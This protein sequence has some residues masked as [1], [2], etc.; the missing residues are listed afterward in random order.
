MADPENHCV[1]SICPNHP[2]RSVV[3]ELPFAHSILYL[4]MAVGLAICLPRVPSF[5]FNPTAPITTPTNTSKPVVTRGPTANFTFDAILDL[6]MNT[7]G[8]IIPLHMNN[9]RANVFVVDTNKLVAQGNTG[10][11]NRKGG[12]TQ[13]LDVPILVNYVASND[14]DTTCKYTLSTFCCCVA[15]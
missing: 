10:S 14:T 8:N 1:D 11:F 15:C 3:R 5:A 2:V 6:E 4:S 13:R 12:A 9:I 7:G